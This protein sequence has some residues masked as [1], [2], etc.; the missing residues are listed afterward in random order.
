VHNDTYWD[1]ATLVTSQPPATPTPPPTATP[2]PMPTA[3]ASPVPAATATPTAEPS[4]TPTAP[5]TPTATPTPL[6]PAV[7]VHVVRPGDTLLSLA[8]EYGTSVSA[9]AQANAL[10]DPNII[11]VNQRLLV[12]LS[13]DGTPPL[14][15]TTYLTQPGDTLTILA[16]RYRTTAEAI[17]RA[18]GVLH[19]NQPLPGGLRLAMPAAADGV[20]L[21]R[22]IHLVQPGDPPSALAL[23]HNTTP[24]AIVLTNGLRFPYLLPPGQTLVIPES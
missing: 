21:E 1:D 2:V 20:R 7:T 13:Q 17:A 15:V 10:A 8:A 19:P 5:A 12:P 23:A 3:T 18:N 4:P 24:W 14:E 22:A 11:Y 9:L 6:P 16:Y